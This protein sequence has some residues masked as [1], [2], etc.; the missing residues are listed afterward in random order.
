MPNK[1]DKSYMIAGVY[2]TIAIGS[3]QMK[4]LS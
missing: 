4:I 3:C 2:E 1:V